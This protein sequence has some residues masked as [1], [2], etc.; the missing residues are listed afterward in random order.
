MQSKYEEELITYKSLLVGH[1]HPDFAEK[2]PIMDL[3]LSDL[4]L[5]VFV[6]KE[7]RGINIDPISLQFKEDF[8]QFYKPPARFI[9]PNLLKTAKE[10]FNRLKGYLYVESS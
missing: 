5:D 4:A 6:P 7:W 1:V 3:L 10:E 8:P 2:T 9:S